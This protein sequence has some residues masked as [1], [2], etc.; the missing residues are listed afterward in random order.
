MSTSRPTSADHAAVGTGGSGPRI[1][2][3]RGAA[4]LEPENT[5][6]SFRR[7]LADGADGIECDVHLSAD[8]EVIV[9]HDETIDRTVLATSPIVSG[10]LADLTREQLA[11]IRV[12]FGHRQEG[13]RSVAM[14]V[15][16]MVQQKAADAARAV[17]DTD[18]DEDPGHDVPVLTD[19]LNL[20]AP[21]TLV[22]VK[23]PEAADAV[24]RILAERF[25]EQTYED[26]ADAPVVVISFY[27][28]ALAAIRRSAPQV[29]IGLVVKT[30]NDEV[31]E[32]VAE[33]SAE[34]LC[35]HVITVGPEDRERTREMGVEL[36]LWT[37]NTEDHLRKGLEIGADSL[38]TDDSGWARRTIAQN[39]VGEAS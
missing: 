38:S 34:M 35:V 26:L 21:Q 39:P 22:E 11:S 19:V 23:A 25:G 32:K 8:G 13:E 3:H 7:A 30:T 18:G 5:M 2:G 27:P 16:R 28:D 4:L 37:V 24:G 29:P 10:A 9:M 1:I 20:E 36:N 17:L 6:V 14:K 33:L 12:G 15:G 31:Y